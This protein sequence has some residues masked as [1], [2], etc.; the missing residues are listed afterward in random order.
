MK[1]MIGRLNLVKESL[2]ERISRKDKG[3]LTFIEILVAIAVVLIVT[4]PLYK[5]IATSTFVTIKTW[6]AGFLPNIFS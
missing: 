3:G 1:K 4:Y 5:D 6:F 2:K